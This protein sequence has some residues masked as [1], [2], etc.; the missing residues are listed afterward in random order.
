MNFKSGIFTSSVLLFT[1]LFVENSFGQSRQRMTYAEL[2]QKMASSDPSNL[3]L[4]NFDFVDKIDPFQEKEKLGLSFSPDS[5]IHISRRVSLF[6]CRFAGGLVLH[7]FSFKKDLTLEVSGLLANTPSR[8]ELSPFKITNCV[9]TSLS[10]FMDKGTTPII[11]DFRKN[12]INGRL[13]VFAYDGI[14]DFVENNINLVSSGKKNDL[15]IFA[16]GLGFVFSDNRIHYQYDSLTNTPFFETVIGAQSDKVG[17]SDNIFAGH[18]SGVSDSFTVDKSIQIDLA[19]GVEGVEFTGNHF[20]TDVSLSLGFNLKSLAFHG[21]SFRRIGFYPFKLPDEHS[22][23]EWS[24]FSD[25]NVGLVLGPYGRSKTFYTGES[26]EQLEDRLTYRELMRFYKK[27]YDEYKQSGDIPSSNQVYIRLKDLETRLLSYEYSREGTFNQFFRVALNRLLKFYTS[28]GTDPAQAL[29]ASV[30]IVCIFAVFYFFFP[31]SWD[32]VPKSQLLQNGKNLFRKIE[33]GYAGHVLTFVV[34]LLISVANAL[35]LSLNAFVTLGFGEIP[36]NGVARYVTV[37]QGF[38]GWFLLSIF[39][40][41][42]FN[43]VLY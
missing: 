22:I 16:S 40:V 5:L 13:A 9:F 29:V 4:E 25:S 43:Q 28:Y 31:S 30:W 23:I 8:D 41:S 15:P 34:A 6:D 20:D 42:L 12:T 10:L 1:F 3:V 38:L 14:Y 18:V 27:F 11:L 26:G 35:T 37:F 24:D 21:N 36:T 19:K 32:T 39:T 2:F 17:F 7:R 33:K